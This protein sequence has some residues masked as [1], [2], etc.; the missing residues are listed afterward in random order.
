MRLL[1]NS[2]AL[3]LV[4]ILAVTAG[5]TYNYAN[6]IGGENDYVPVVKVLNQDNE[7]ISLNEMEVE[8]LKLEG[9]K[10]TI[11]NYNGGGFI[12]ESRDCIGSLEVDVKGNNIVNSRGACALNAKSTDIKFAGDGTISFNEEK[13][14]SQDSFKV[15]DGDFI[16]DGPRVIYNNS[17]DGIKVLSTY[18]EVEPETEETT[19]ETEE[20]TEE[21]TEEVTEEN[22]EEIT[23]EVT[24]EVTEEI[25][26]E[27]TE[28]NTEEVTEENN[29]N[30]G[31]QSVE[32]DDTESVEN[33]EEITE[34]NTD[35]TETFEEKVEGEF[36]S[37]EY[38]K[39][40][41][42]SGNLEIYLSAK[43]DNIQVGKKV[44][45]Q[46]IFAD[47]I[48]LNGGTIKE[49]YQNDTK[50]ISILAE[51]KDGICEGIVL[52]ANNDFVGNNSRIIFIILAGTE[53]FL[54]RKTE[55]FYLACFKDILLL[56]MSKNNL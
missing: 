44:Y 12:I 55:M 38:C 18:K 56:E 42:I 46:G 41:M 4:I 36:L 22:T 16:I 32:E 20:N 7:Y 53:R 27:I 31:I 2:V 25:T 26:E 11:E 8:G 30:Y 45:G 13:E 34:D 15:V 24:E 39:F 54:F 3:M 21:V 52:F 23:E 40:E 29:D 35:E 19:E 10:L 50:D 37:K 17:K 47:N 43:E 5:W 48:L 51:T 1:K 49:E 9:N 33:T 6:E 28:E 14:V